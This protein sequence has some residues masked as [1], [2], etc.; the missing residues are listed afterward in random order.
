MDMTTIP[1]TKEQY[2]RGLQEAILFGINRGAAVERKKQLPKLV[3]MLL[4]GVV[5]GV[6]AHAIGASL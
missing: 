5:M 3:F 6:L 1:T 2:I 4:A